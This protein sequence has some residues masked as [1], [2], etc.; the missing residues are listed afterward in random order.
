MPRAGEKRHS[1][2]R[3]NGDSAVPIKIEAPCTSTSSAATGSRNSL[4]E[5]ADDVT[6]LYTAAEVKQLLEQKAQQIR[7]QCAVEYKTKIRELES[8]YANEKAKLLAEVI[9]DDTRHADEK[10]RLNAK[11]ESLEAK[12]KAALEALAVS[13]SVKK[14]NIVDEQ[15]IRQ[16]MEQHFA[17]ERRQMVQRC[18]EEK[19][20]L[21]RTFVE[22]NQKAE[23]E[24]ASMKELLESQSQSIATLTNNIHELTAKATSAESETKEARQAVWQYYAHVEVLQKEVEVLR[25]ASHAFPAPPASNATAAMP[26]SNQIYVGK[27]TAAMTEDVLRRYFSQFGV[28]TRVVVKWHPDQVSGYAFVSFSTPAEAVRAL[29]WNVHNING[30]DIFVGPSRRSL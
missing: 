28:V 9:Q 21:Q 1:N 15:A 30:Q 24:I 5:P 29:T 14:E 3:N 26:T 10:A 13:V 11:I 27:L 17:E 19:Q 6:S 23:Q 8:N 2:E 7:S 20:E 16:E 4:P 18:D 12:L 22:A 25:S